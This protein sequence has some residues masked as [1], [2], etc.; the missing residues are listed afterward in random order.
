MFCAAA[1]AAEC[2]YDDSVLVP[3]VPVRLAGLVVEDYKNDNVNTAVVVQV[4][5]SDADRLTMAVVEVN[6]DRLAMV[7]LGGVRVDVLEDLKVVEDVSSVILFWLGVVVLV[8]GK[9]S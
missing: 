8:I 2:N 4:A 9:T 5:V 1:A 6:G 3:E 7:V